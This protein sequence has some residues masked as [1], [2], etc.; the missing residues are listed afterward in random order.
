MPAQEP[1]QESIINR[2]WRFLMGD[3]KGAEA[4][5][6]DDAG[7]A[8]IH[9]PH[10]FSL[11]YFRQNRFYVGYGWYRKTLPLAA[12]DLENRDGIRKLRSHFIEALERF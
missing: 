12:S 10:S 6:F 3:A 2:E 4:A 7:W 5:A 9:L 1:R 8:R 11:P